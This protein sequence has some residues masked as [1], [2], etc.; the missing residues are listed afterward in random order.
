MK[1]PQEPTRVISLDLVVFSQ[2]LVVITN[3]IKAE[4]SGN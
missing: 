4:N 3:Y 1:E 2:L